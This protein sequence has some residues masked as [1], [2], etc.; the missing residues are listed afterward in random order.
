MTDKFVKTKRIYV[1]DV[2][3]EIEIEMTVEPDA[4]GPHAHPSE[5]DRIDQV[6]R[7]LKA[8]DLRAAAKK[9][10]LYSIKPLAM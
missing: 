10:K 7:Q 3:A 2:M 5:L 9:A 8:G 4:W 1:G 6:R